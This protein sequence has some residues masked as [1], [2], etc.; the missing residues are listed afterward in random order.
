MLTWRSPW[1]D[2]ILLTPPQTN[3]TTLESIQRWCELFCQK[4]QSNYRRWV[5][6]EMSQSNINQCHGL[7]WTTDSELNIK[8]CVWSYFQLQ[9]DLNSTLSLWT[10]TQ[11]YPQLYLT[12]CDNT[13]ETL[14]TTESERGRC[15]LRLHISMDGNSKTE[16]QILFKRCNM[17]QKVYSNSMSMKFI[18]YKNKLL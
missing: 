12:N 17:F 10:K 8:K 5:L 14:K 6:L 18:T 16:T 7:L 3:H 9:Y 15:H 13:R 1:L 11:D 4:I 2:Y